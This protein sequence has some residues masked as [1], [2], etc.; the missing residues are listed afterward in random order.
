MVLSKSELI[1]SLQHE[2]RILLHLCGKVDRAKLDYRPS[3]KQRSTLELVRYLSM[4]GPTLVQ[5]ALSEPPD[6]ELWT[7]AEE[8]AK[9]LDFDAAV[10]AIDAQSERYEALLADVPDTRF[11]NAFTDFDGSQTTIG[12][13]L[14]TLVLM[15]VAA[16]KTQLFVYL[17]AG[18]R[19]ELSSANLWYGAD[20]PPA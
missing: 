19:E 4:M 9:A 1:S 15:G 10:A 3:P 20:A 8:G 11:R 6:I 13:F 17:K 18:G 14:V 7:A 12:S 2:V 5:Y 16:Y